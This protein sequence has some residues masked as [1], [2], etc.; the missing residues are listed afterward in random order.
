MKKAMLTDWLLRKEI[1]IPG[2]LKKVQTY[3]YSERTIELRAWRLHGG[4]EGFAA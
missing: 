1:T 2:G 4:P 3:I